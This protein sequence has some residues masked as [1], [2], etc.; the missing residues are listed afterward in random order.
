MRRDGGG[1]LLPG[2]DPPAAGVRGQHARGERG[3]RGL[4]NQVPKS[5]AVVTLLRVSN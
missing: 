3:S 2:V 1:Y 4:D 5:V